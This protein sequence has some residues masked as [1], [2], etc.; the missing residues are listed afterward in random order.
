MFSNTHTHIKTVIK[1]RGGNNMENKMTTILFIIFLSIVYNILLC[2]LSTHN[3]R[4]HHGPTQNNRYSSSYHRTP[5]WLPPRH[6]ILREPGSGWVKISRR[7]RHTPCPICPRQGTPCG[8]APQDSSE[9]CVR[10]GRS[11]TTSR[12]SPL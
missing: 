9:G 11:D 7:H 6:R 5:Y 1:T 8:C 4:R 3:T 12:L 2:P 10:T